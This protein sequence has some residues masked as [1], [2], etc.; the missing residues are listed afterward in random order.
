[1]G[2]KAHERHN[3]IALEIAQTIA[4]LPYVDRLI[5]VESVAAAIIGTLPYHQGHAAGVEW[6]IST[7]ADGV[8]ARIKETENG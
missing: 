3:R 8:R 7:L 5:V 6:A 1:M 2:E 4:K